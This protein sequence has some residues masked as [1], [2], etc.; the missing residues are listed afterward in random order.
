M[1]TVQFDE[2][3]STGGTSPSLSTSSSI[4][5]R[6]LRIGDSIFSALN[7]YLEETRYRSLPVRRRFI[8]LI[9]EHVGEIAFTVFVPAFVAIM[10]DHVAPEAFSDLQGWK[11]II[12]IFLTSGSLVLMMSGAPPDLTMVGVNIA[13]ILTTIIT[14]EEAIKGLAS[15]SILAVGILFVVAKGLEQAGTISILLAMCLGS[16]STVPGAIIR[17][18]FPVAIISA[19]MNNT[20]V[21]VSEALMS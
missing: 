9:K 19:F 4:F 21:V 15:S 12:A 7:E 17:L 6:S 10:K 8:N 14:P 3:R 5:A 2:L 1:S 11:A 16:P 13:L 18:S 20:P